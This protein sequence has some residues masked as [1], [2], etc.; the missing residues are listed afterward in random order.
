MKRI[1]MSVLLLI[2]AASAAFA[3]EEEPPHWT[4]EGEEGPEHWGELSEDYALCST[5]AEQSPIDIVEAVAEDVGEVTFDYLPSKINLFN[6]GHT[7]QEDYDAGSSITIGDTVY[8]LVQ[9]HFHTPSEH[10]ING[11][12]MPLEL[13]FVHRSEAGNLAV[14]GVM[15]VEG[16]ENPTIAELWSHLPTIAT[17]RRTIDA[18]TF[19]A[20]DLLPENVGHYF[21]Y[22][23]SLTT[24]PCSEGVLWTVLDE[25]ITVSTEQIEAF[26]AVFEL[27]ARPVQ[28]LNERELIDDAG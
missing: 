28:P 6:N 19:N 1:V 9:F 15:L 26:H 17:E 24:P 4:Y 20:A 3:Q 10:A 16:E 18:I 11:E 21:R 2:A 8:N 12:L 13:H 23:G 25:P 7:I 27:N 22:N 5:G 14:V